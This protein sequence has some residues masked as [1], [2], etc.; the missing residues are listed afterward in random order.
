MNKTFSV[1]LFTS[2]TAVTLQALPLNDIIN[3]AVADTRAEFTSPALK[4]EQLAV[5]VI[6]LRGPTPGRA[7]YRGAERIYPAS[8]IKLF[9]LAYAHRLM[10]DG[11]LTDTPELQ[12]ALRDMIVE[13]YNDAT[14]SVVDYITGTTGGP[15]LPPAE[16]AA[17]SRRSATRMCSPCAKPGPRDPTGARNRMPPFIS[18]AGIFS[19]PTMR[20]A[21]WR[22]WPPAAASHRHVPPR[23]SRSSLAIH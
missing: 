23:C 12:R 13:S 3:Q 11:K 10:E 14:A 18:R 2:I 19:R 4:P 9:Y 20:P 5:T 1:L 21:S 17:I 7:D 8:V 16:L 15:E 22:R 6:D